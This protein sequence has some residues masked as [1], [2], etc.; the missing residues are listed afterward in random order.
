MPEG[1]AAPTPTTPGAQKALV[2]LQDAVNRIEEEGGTVRDHIVALG[3]SLLSY[4]ESHLSRGSVAT[5]AG[6][7]IAGSQGADKA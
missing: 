6:A 3:A 7:P 2:S 5:A 1:V 4:L